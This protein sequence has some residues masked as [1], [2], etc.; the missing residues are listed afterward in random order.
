MIIQC[1]KC[2]TKFNL[3]ES[4]LRPQGSRV[5][6]SLCKN[7]FTAYP[8]VP[9][10]PSPSPG[11]YDFQETVALDGPPTHTEVENFGDHEFDFDKLF[12][13]STRDQ[14]EPKGSPSDF[15]SVDVPDGNDTLSERSPLDPEASAG[16]I[17][18]KLTE[19]LKE[20][21]QRRSEAL[22]LEE[23]KRR[24]PWMLILLLFLLLAGGAAAVFFWAP[25]L[26]PASVRML[27]TPPAKVPQ[28]DAGVRRLS[29]QGV[30]GS[31]VDS[32]KAGP[33]FV[34]R[35]SVV[36]DYPT[37]RSFILVK[38]S[39]LDD[40]GLVIR[41]KEAY[42]GNIFKDEEL[43]KMNIGEINEALN[44][45]SG[46]SDGN[47]DIASGTAVPIMI[48]FEELPEN[49]SEFSIEAVRSSVSAQG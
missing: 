35:G 7:T 30:S 15:D 19:K 27:I 33:L 9:S 43:Q 11:E 16:T 10:D 39:L 25:G 48:V 37:P 28:V 32:E 34:I 49:L 3:N 12:E 42:A 26:I 2:L 4:V 18:E 38:G 47:V 36:N 41:E 14:E 21:S 6:C 13:E 46:G 23:E 8:P 20:R 22:H 1:E 17:S 24:S 31:F 44:R 29:F 45:P 40:K 5:R